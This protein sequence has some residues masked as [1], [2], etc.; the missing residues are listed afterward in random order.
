M[1]VDGVEAR[2]PELEAA[3]GVAQPRTGVGAGDAGGG[4]GQQVVLAVVGRGG[5]VSPLDQDGVG[6]CRQNLAG[7][8]LY[9]GGRRQVVSAGSAAAPTRHLVPEIEEGMA[10]HRVGRHDVAQFHEPSHDDF[11]RLVLDQ[12]MSGG[13]DHDQVQHHA[14]RLFGAVLLLPTPYSF[15]KFHHRLHDLHA[16]HHTNL[17]AIRDHVVHQPIEMFRQEIHQGRVDAIHT[18]TTLGRQACG[19]G[20][21]VSTEVVDGEHVRLYASTAGRVGTGYR[22][23]YRGAVELGHDSGALGGRNEGTD[24]VREGGENQGEQT[25]GWHRSLWR[26]G[27]Y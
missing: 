25:A 17:L 18:H 12:L 26:V 8:I 23:D 1:G 14:L 5:E 6:A 21:R 2:A 16:T 9:I 27:W 24:G 4:G 11:E 7:G 10:L 22:V 19:D 13:A 20:H 15:Q 3:D